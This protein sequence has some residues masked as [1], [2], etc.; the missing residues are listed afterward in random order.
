MEGGTLQDASRNTTAHG[1][2]SAFFATRGGRTRSVRG[3]AYVQSQAQAGMLAHFLLNQSEY[4]R[5]KY[6]MAGCPG[7]SSRRLG[8][9]VTINDSGVMSATRDAF[10]T[11]VSWRLG[12]QGFSQ[13][14]EAIDASQL[15]PYQSEGY[16][17]VGTNTLVATAKRMVY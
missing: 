10:L 2:N 1:S 8:D 14:L 7:K 4:P 12:A 13:D 5:L 3:N 6:R 11:A 9:L 17:V 16:F 15:Y